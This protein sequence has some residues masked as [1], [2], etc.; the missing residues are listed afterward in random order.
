[1]LKVLEGLRP[2]TRDDYCFLSEATHP[3]QLQQQWLVMAGERG[4][5]WSNPKFATYAEGWLTHLLDIVELSMAGIIER[6]LTLQDAC[7][8][9]IANDRG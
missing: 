9:H 1:M 2:E 6:S 7:W 3:N 8:P 5:N 4:N